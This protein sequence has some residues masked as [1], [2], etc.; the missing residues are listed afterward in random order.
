MTNEQRMS[1]GFALMKAE[2]FAKANGL[3]ADL[4]AYATIREMANGSGD[5]AVILHTTDPANEEVDVYVTITQ[6]GSTRGPRGV[7]TAD[8]WSVA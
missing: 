2:E 1:V 7:N 4:V 3:T 5:F 6:T 8:A